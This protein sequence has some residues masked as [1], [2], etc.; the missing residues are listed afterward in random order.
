MKR[1]RGF[2]F[3]LLLMLLLTGCQQTAGSGNGSGADTGAS[4]SEAGI[5]PDAGEGADEGVPDDAGEGA[6]D[7]KEAASPAADDTAPLADEKTQEKNGEIMV[8]FTSDVHCGIDQGFGYAGLAQIRDSYEAQGYTTILVDN[9]DAVQGELIGT[10]TH[11]EAVIELMNDLHYDLAIPGNHEFD[12]GMEQ[13]LNLT[14]MAEFPYVSCNFNNEDQLVFSPYKIL[15]ACG[16]KIAFVGVTTP[17]TITSSTPAYFQDY[18]GEFVYDFR[19]DEDGTALYE[20]VQKAVD[21]AR[22]EGADVIYVLGHMGMGEDFSPWSYSDVISHT[23]GVDAF[24]DGHS[25][26]TEQVVMKDKDGKEIPRSAVG[27]KLNAIGYS[28]IVPGK[29]IVETDILSWPNKTA[30][31]ELLQIDNRLSDHVAAAKARIEAQLTEVVARTDVDLTISDPVEKNEKGDPVRM[32]R[33]AETNLGDLCADAY[34][35]QGGADIGLINGG[36]I[37]QSI[38]KGDITYG[39]IVSVHPFG[40]ELC[41]VEATGQQILDALEWGVRKIP[42]ETGGF[43]QVSGLSYEID[44]SVPS[45]CESDRNGMCTGIR[46]ERRVRNVKVGEEAIDPDKVYTVASI[47]YILLSHG[48]GNT[49]F[50]GAKLVQDCIKLDNQMLIDYI[51]QT[52]GG[53]I[54]DAYADPYGDGRITII[55]DAK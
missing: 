18:Q 14:R 28:H 50:D 53:T 30:A 52:L 26:D 16:M 36:G 3:T 47:K 20:A 13:F 42:E 38:K 5:V 31:P 46:G 17:K 6:A 54:G 21:G 25:H 10:L 35:E 24:L 48:D 49:A 7:K 43:L 44:V 8:L 15:E 19:Q 51:T 41:V 40:N 23:S 34:R 39:D 12:Y 55:D 9:G 11:G 33:R 32:V 27:Q 37:R 4:V 2:L 45:G 29:G 22:A 1:S